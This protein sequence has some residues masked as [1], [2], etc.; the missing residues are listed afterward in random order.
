[1]RTKGRPDLSKTDLTPEELEGIHAGAVYDAGDGRIYEISL[2]HHDTLKLVLYC[3][4]CAIEQFGYESIKI[5]GEQ[6][7]AYSCTN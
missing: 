6:R 5:H 4:I 1:V 2:L 7:H 3:G